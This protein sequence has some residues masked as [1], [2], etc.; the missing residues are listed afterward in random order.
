VNIVSAIPYLG[1]FPWSFAFGLIAGKAYVNQSG[2]EETLLIAL[3]AAAL[4]MAFYI[5]IVAL[6]AVVSGLWSAS[7]L[8]Q[9]M[10]FSSIVA[11]ILVPAVA[12]GYA[13]LG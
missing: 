5:A 1:L 7:S 13:G 6:L 11:V 8:R 2:K 10:F 3:A 12:I 9:R 4:G